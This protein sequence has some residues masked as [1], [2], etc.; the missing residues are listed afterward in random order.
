[1]NQLP[2]TLFGHW[3]HSFEEDTPGVRVYRPASVELPR[4]RGRAALEINPDGSFVEHGIGRGD[5]S[6]DVAGAWSAEGEHTLRISYGA[7]QRSPQQLEIIEHDAGIL[8]VRA[9]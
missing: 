4:A 9:P 5:A 7:A 6:T 2:S 3:R 8:K 1:M